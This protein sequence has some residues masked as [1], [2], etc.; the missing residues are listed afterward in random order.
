M[1]TVVEQ[2]G[3]NLKCGWSPGGNGTVH[4][5]NKQAGFEAGFEEVQTSER[6]GG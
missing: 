4:V 2:K 3:L 1:C 5:N 6:T